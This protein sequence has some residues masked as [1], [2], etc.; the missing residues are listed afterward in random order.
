MR[1]IAQIN[2]AGESLEAKLVQIANCTVTS[3]TIPTTD[4]GIDS[5]LTI[6]DGT[7]SMQLKIDHDSDIPGLAT[8]TGSFTV[9][10]IIQQ[11]D[12]LRPFDTSYSVAPRNRIDLG[13]AASGPPLITIA[14]AR[15]DVDPTTGVSP[16]DYVPD[17]LGQAVKVRGVVTSVDFRSASGTE[18][19]I[20]DPTGGIDLFS[21]SLNPTLNLGDSVEAVGT[22]AHFNG[23]TEIT[24]SSAVVLAAGTTPAVSPQIVTCSQ[25]G[26]NGA[27]EPLEGK[28]IRVNNVTLVAP[29]ATFGANTN[30]LITDG[31]GIATI[32]IDSD[33]DID[34]TAPPAGT[35]SIIGVLGQFD[36][37]SP[38]DSG[39][40]LFPRIRATDFQP[41]V[42]AP[43]SM[44]T[45]AGSNQTAVL[46]SPFGTALKAKV[47]DSGGN[48]I[49]NVNVTFTAPATGPSG[50]FSGDATV[51]TDASGV[52]TA[53]TFTANS[54]TGSYVV[55]A[56]SG[57][58][59]TTFN[60]TN[61]DQSATHFNISAP[62]TATLGVPFNIVVT[63]LD[64]SGA[65][66][67]TYT[68]TVHF[69]SSGSATLPADYTF[70]GADAGVHTFSVTLNASGSQMIT[71]TDIA[72]GSITGSASVTVNAAPATHLSLT[73]PASS[74]AGVPF[75]VTVTALDASNA[76]V[77]S[78]AGTVHFTSS[79][80]GT[81]PADYTF[82]SG[83][84][85]THSF[86]VT[87]T[88]TGTQTI[89][90][91]DG[92][93]SGSTNITVNTPA[94]TTTH[95]SIAAP[96]SVNVGVPFTVTVSA[97]DSSN[98]IVASYAGT[99]HFASSGPASLPP[100]YTFTATDAGAHVFS[101]TLNA[102]GTQ[103]I[104][105]NDATSAATAT[106]SASCPTVPLVLGPVNVAPAVCAKSA[107]NIASAAAGASTYSW[108]ITNGTITAGQ[109]TSSI[110][111]TAGATGTV[112]F[113][114][115]TT[116]A[117]GCAGPTAG[118]SSQ[119]KPLPSVRIPTSIHTCASAAI[120]IPVTLGGTPP[121]TITWSDGVQQTSLSNT[122]FRRFVT[123]SNSALR[124]VSV[125]DASCA[126]STGSATLFIIV[127]SAPVISDQPQDVKI[128]GG[129]RATLAV[130]ATNAV[131]Y[132][133]FEGSVGDETLPV[134][135]EPIFVTPPL[136]ATTTYWVKV[137][138]Q[139]DTAKS[140][141]VVVT[142]VAGK[143]RGVGH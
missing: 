139:C 65:T 131:S 11:D 74:T 57:A 18:V 83:D 66:A 113:L 53:P 21:T 81:L 126:S 16:D 102:T 10:G 2:S 94:P 51:A 27:G 123:A 116:N 112:S 96:S 72:V 42:A 128:H 137:S 75:S 63:A 47:F 29:P 55:T 6:A 86:S 82:A 70:V 45:I 120:F 135:T 73:G 30:Y 109:G 24:L 110:T 5:F 140:R 43:A 84:A 141:Q 119:I 19:Y 4:S 104:T 68:G 9:I 69:T 138:N 76:I 142:V 79:S 91:S 26:D 8:P 34:G 93:I 54:L 143:R 48:P 32:R 33:T 62:A 46:N 85:G 64:I 56:T 117:F 12:A 88:T 7:G 71:A 3:G 97:L 13:A 134:G 108:Q 124:I 40:Q 105:V 95:V 35:F 136:R 60:L 125:H 100:A 58:V 28:L 99:V 78:Y 38:F 25:L 67:T 39:Y 92:A 130:T 107:G 122:T 101:I 59:S 14:E 127:D 111:F 31:T 90:V 49:P 89:N 133:W 23:L 80:A 52:A 44:A 20:Q 115:N 1:T 98:V 121:F 22:I 132:Q 37:S 50:T 129:E 41:P 77:S 114:V 118:G 61:V 15:A 17:R 87:L 36:S 103:T 106:I